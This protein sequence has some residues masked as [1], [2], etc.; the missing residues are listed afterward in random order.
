ML[1]EAT[2]NGIRI[3]ENPEA[4]R[5]VLDLSGKAAYK[6]FRLEEPY[7]AVFD[8]KGTTASTKLVMPR[9]ESPS[10]LLKLIR[11][12][13]RDKDLRIVLETKQKTK[14]RAFSL[15]PIPPH[16]DRIVIDLYPDKPLKK[17]VVKERIKAARRDVVVAIDAGHGGEDPGALGPRGIQEKQVVLQISKKLRAEIEKKKGFKGLLVRKGD[18]YMA[19]RKRT[20]FAR[21]NGADLFVSIHADAFTSSKVSGASIYTLSGGGA[22]SEM[23]RFLANRANESDLFSGAGTISIKGRADDVA[24]TIVDMIMDGKTLFSVKAGNAVLSRL[25]QATKLH[26]K[27]VEQAGF[28]VLKTSDIPSILVETGFISN[29][30]EARRL[31]QKDHQN[32]LSRAIAAGIWD[33]FYE[34]PPPGTLVASLSNEVTYRVQRGDTLSGIGQ[35]FGV[36]SKA[37][38][39]RNALRTSKIRI[40]QTLIIPRRISS[41]RGA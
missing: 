40:G 24:K 17:K 11:S 14:V 31:S 15:Q 25:Q 4:T 35:E 20:E 18:Y 23:G 32:H 9:V 41:Q 34:N 2:L 39:E 28:L 16:T 6:Y 13:K 38:K 7:R 22:E 37:I 26:K 27:Q 19:H 5:V 10:K 1:Q 3:H 8:L 33:F 12:G 36:S 29:P 30:K 21:E